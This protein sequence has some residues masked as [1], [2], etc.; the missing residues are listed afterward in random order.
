[1]TV[2]RWIHE[3]Q[4]MAD[5]DLL[6]DGAVDRHP[7]REVACATTREAPEAPCWRPEDADPLRMF[8][9]WAGGPQRMTAV[10]TRTV[11]L[12]PAE[13]VRL[14]ANSFPVRLPASGGGPSPVNPVFFVGFAMPAV[15]VDVQ[16][17]AGGCQ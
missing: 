5:T 14:T 4:S 11:R 6:P 16:V 17:L 3:V 12:R 8:M 15:I 2:R 7:R 13:P 9:A 10:A 1:L